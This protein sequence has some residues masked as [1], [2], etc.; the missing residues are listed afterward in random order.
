[1]PV[2]ALEVEDHAKVASYFRKIKDKILNPQF[3]GSPF[4]GSIASHKFDKNNRLYVIDI[5][6]IYPRYFFNIILVFMFLAGISIQLILG[7]M[8]IAWVIY[9]MT[10]VFLLILNSFW[11]P[12]LYRWII[13]YQLR[14]LMGRKVL[15]KRADAQALRRLSIGKV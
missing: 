7:W 11:S 4:A 8:T 10:L 3:I 12:D 13:K 5:A 2:F 14:R 1:M 9:G 6:P 15:V